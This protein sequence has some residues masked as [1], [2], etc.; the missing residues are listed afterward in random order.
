[1][2]IEE[3]RRAEESLL[4]YMPTVGAISSVTLLRAVE[5]LE[6]HNPDTLRYAYW[7]LVHDQKILRV[8]EGVKLP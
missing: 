7:S 4:N 1:M 2:I 8:P 5:F 3:L 6:I